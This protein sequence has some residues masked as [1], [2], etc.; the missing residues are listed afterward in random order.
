MI[1]R[2]IVEISE[3]D[4]MTYHFYYLTTTSNDF[5]LR[6]YEISHPRPGLTPRTALRAVGSGNIHTALLNALFNDSYGILILKGYMVAL[7]KQAEFFYLIDSHARDL[8]GMFNP[9]GT[10]V[11]MKFANILE[12]EQYLYC[13][14]VALNTNLFEIVPLPLT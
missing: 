5:E 11:V 8:N 14:A 1:V 13:L 7:I 9:N 6:Y 2:H 4:V 3:N 10:A 12:L